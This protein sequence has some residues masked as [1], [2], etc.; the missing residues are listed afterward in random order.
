MY[1]G[2]KSHCKGK[3]LEG[4][5]KPSPDEKNMREKTKKQNQHSPLSMLRLSSPLK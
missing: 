2:H 5:K 3:Q 4:L 1:Q